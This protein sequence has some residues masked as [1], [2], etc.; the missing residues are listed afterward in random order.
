MVA[1]I[2]DRIAVFLILNLPLSPSKKKKVMEKFADHF[3]P[4]SITGLRGINVPLASPSKLVMFQ[5]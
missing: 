3:I 4:S 2:K 5:R 1:V